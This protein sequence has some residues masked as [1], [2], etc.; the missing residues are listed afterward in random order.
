STSASLVC[1]A[2]SNP[3]PTT[4]R[5]SRPYAVRATCLPPTNPVQ[6][7][8]R[9]A[10]ASAAREGQ[11]RP[12]QPRTRRAKSVIDLVLRATAARNCWLGLLFAAVLLTGPFP[13]VARAD[14][15]LP[16]PSGPIILRVTGSISRTN[17]PGRAEFDQKMVEALGLE[18]LTTSTNW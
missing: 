15:T 11:A 14:D 9:S 3:I 13:A 6:S 18:R 4:R 16:V 2:R 7:A 12:R 1:A 5:S 17:A 8:S 10:R